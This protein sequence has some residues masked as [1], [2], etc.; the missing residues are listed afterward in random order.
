MK[1]DNTTYFLRRG[2]CPVCRSKMNKKSVLEYIK[3]TYR[4]H[5]ECETCESFFVG[6]RGSGILV[7]KNNNFFVLYEESEDGSIAI[8][9]RFSNTRNDRDLVKRFKQI[10]SVLVNKIKLINYYYDNNIM[11]YRFDGQHSFRKC[12]DK[13][14]KEIFEDRIVCTRRDFE[15]EVLGLVDKILSYR[16]NEILVD[17]ENYPTSVF[18]GFETDEGRIK[19]LKNNLHI[20]KFIDLIHKKTFYVRRFNKQEFITLFKKIFRGEE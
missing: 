14:F 3:N 19:F 5:F 2:I 13:S 16:Y 8:Y 12:I 11:Y 17:D 9:K 20:N 18:R 7:Q 10:N 1:H 4:N 15:E 6:S